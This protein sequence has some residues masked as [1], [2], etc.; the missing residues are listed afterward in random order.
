VFN[1]VISPM[2]PGGE[3]TITFFF[4][5]F[6]LDDTEERSKEDDEVE[7]AVYRIDDNLELAKVCVGEV[8]A[9]QLLFDNIDT[10]IL[11]TII[12][13]KRLLVGRDDIMMNN[14][15]VVGEIITPR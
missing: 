1:D 5:L 13:T 12:N 15:Q 11:T 9:L 4:V 10:A 14:G 7:V 6:V 2:P 8:K 3:I